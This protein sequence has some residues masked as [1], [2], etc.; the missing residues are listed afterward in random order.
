MRTTRSRPSWAW[1]SWARTRW[2]ACGGLNVPPRMPRRRGPRGSAD[3][4]VALHEVLVRAQL[5]QADGAA[6]VELVRGVADLR[7]HA[8]LAAVGEAGRGVDV[9][10]RR[11]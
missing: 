11:V 5:A 1:A 6:R 4:P 10:A 8:E 9:D 2:P 3:V 7:A